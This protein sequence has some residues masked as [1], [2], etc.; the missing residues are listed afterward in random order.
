MTNLVAKVS[1]GWFN[2]TVRHKKVKRLQSG[3]SIGKEPQGK[4][5]KNGIMVESDLKDIETEDLQIFWG[6][7]GRS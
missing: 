6:S 3:K 2:D 1:L 7:F 5:T 4:L